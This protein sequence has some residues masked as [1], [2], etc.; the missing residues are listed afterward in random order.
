MLKLGNVFYTCPQTC[1]VYMLKKKLFPRSVCV[2]L[3]ERQHAT[4][5]SAVSAEEQTLSRQGCGHPFLR[6]TSAGEGLVV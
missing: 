2:H 5:Q 1:D 6:D 3:Q 4:D